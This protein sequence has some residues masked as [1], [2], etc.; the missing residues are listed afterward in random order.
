MGENDTPELTVETVTAVEPDKL[1]D[2]QRSF[3]EEHKAE[4]SEE[5]RGKY[6]PEKKDED[7]FQDNEEEVPPSR[8]PK[9]KAEGEEPP[10][11]KEGEEDDIDDEDEE[12]IGKVVNKKTS[13]IEE[14]LNQAEEREFQ[15]E[16]KAELSDILKAN[17]EY[18][19]YKGRIERFVNHPNRIG[20]I[21]NGLPVTSVVAEALAPVMQR[22]GAIK[23]RAAAKAAAETT[24]DGTTHRPAPKGK[25][26]YSKM[27]DDEIQKTAELVKSGRL[28]Q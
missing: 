10:K 13:K 1:D 20:M 21:R 26:D 22:L 7:E 6:F 23:E 19:K 9:A 17:P 16:V 24:S 11:K 5:Q 27:S 12:V 3:L 14:R 28:V 2:S 8:A 25:V 15:R 18:E 4:L